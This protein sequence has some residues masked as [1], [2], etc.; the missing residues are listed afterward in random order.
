[1]AV[2]DEDV[3]PRIPG[4]AGRA[5]E[6]QKSGLLLVFF[7]PWFVLHYEDNT[8]AKGG[9]LTFEKREAGLRMCVPAGL[10]NAINERCGG[11]LRAR[12]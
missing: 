10:G 4:C 1:M 7:L 3:F 12:R 11:R 8:Q 6:R 9:P 2:S 5:A